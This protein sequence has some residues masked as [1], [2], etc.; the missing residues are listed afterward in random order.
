MS[1]LECFERRRRRRRR[2]GLLRNVVPYLVVMNVEPY[3]AD[4]DV[5]A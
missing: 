3:L 4:C 2:R 5:K 1:V